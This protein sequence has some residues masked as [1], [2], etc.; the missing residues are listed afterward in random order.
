MIFVIDSLFNSGVGCL[1][2]T[3]ALHCRVQG[4]EFCLEFCFPNPVRLIAHPSCVGANTRVPL[5][6]PKNSDMITRTCHGVIT[7]FA[8]APGSVPR[9]VVQ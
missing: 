6:F 8:F 3:Q 4:L 2:D 5:Y 9:V 1:K 7:D